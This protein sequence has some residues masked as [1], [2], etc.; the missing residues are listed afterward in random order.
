MKGRIVM[1][2]CSMLSLSTGCLSKETADLVNNSC[3]E[4]TKMFDE[5]VVYEKCMYGWF[6]YVPENIESITMPDD[7]RYCMEKAIEEG[8]CWIMFDRDVEFDSND[9]LQKYDW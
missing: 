7:L 9:G 2:K 8:C 4:H 3:F 6:V 5:I 1:E